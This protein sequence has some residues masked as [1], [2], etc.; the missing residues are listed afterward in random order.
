MKKVLLDSSAWIE[1]FADGPLA[2]EVERYLKASAPLIVPAIV[3]YEVYKRIKSVKGEEVAMV[4]ASR[5]ARGEIVPVEATLALTA[6]DLSLAHKLAMAD[7]LVLAAARASEAE[8][9]TLDEDF[10]GLP[11]VTILARPRH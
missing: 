5:L 2:D 4:A 8:L 6:A 11:Q 9:V 7:A 3:L 1:F 10:R